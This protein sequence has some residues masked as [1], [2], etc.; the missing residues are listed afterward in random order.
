MSEEAGKDQYQQSFDRAKERLRITGV[1]GVEMPNPG[2]FT[3]T[4]HT[5][6]DPARHVAFNPKT[7]CVTIGSNAIKTKKQ[8]MNTSSIRIFDY[9][10]PKED[11]TKKN[12]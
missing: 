7:G 11:D 6:Q 2:G 8:S 12:K 9:G 3:T 1:G 10:K 5:P 4:G